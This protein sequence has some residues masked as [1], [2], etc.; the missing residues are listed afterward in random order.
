MPYTSG[1]YQGKCLGLERLVEFLQ[2]GVGASAGEKGEGRD[3][4]NIVGS[5]REE[6]R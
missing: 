3:V 4:D 1:L 5:W 2:D 6:R